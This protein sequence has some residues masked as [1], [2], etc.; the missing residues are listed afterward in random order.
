M[1]EMRKNYYKDLN[2]K[3]SLKY[4]N[5][6]KLNMMVAKDKY[7]SMVPNELV[8]DFALLDNVVSYFNAQDCEDTEMRNIFNTKINDIKIAF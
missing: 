5:E 7:G 1:E 6:K 3:E 2:N 8:G 4:F